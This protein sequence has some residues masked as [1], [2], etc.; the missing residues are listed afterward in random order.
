MSDIPD[1]TGYV[2]RFLTESGQLGNCWESRDCQGF[3][4]LCR[5]QIGY[6]GIRV[7]VGFSNPRH[8]RTPG[9]GWWVTCWLPTKLNLGFQR[10]DRSLNRDQW[11]PTLLI[12]LST[13]PIMSLWPRKTAWQCQLTLTLHLWGLSVGFGKIPMNGSGYPLVLK[14]LTWTHW[15]LYPWGGCGYRLP[16]NTQ[17]LSVT[18]PMREADTI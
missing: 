15:N 11:W 1:V 18:I 10:L 9:A 6:T 12:S 3:C 4:N 5:L 13:T 7:Q 17:G 14:T 2:H 16:W 8:T